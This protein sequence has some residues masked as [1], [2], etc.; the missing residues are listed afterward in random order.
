MPIK[1][2]KVN[3][4]HFRFQTSMPYRSRS[5][6]IA[7][8]SECQK[9]SS[10]VCPKPPS[11]KVHTESAVTSKGAHR[12]LRLL[13]SHPPYR[14]SIGQSNLAPADPPKQAASFDLPLSLGILA[15]IGQIPADAFDR[16]AVVGELALDG[17]IRPIKGA[18]SMALTAKAQGITDLIVPAV[19]ML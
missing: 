12:K 19:F 7:P 16:F 18:L 15:G 6:S 11:K 9:Q 17:T 8:T 4:T 2:N 14:Q 1:N 10:S 13:Q 5:K 3:S